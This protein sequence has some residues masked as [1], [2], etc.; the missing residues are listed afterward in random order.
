MFENKK[1]IIK[2]IFII[3]VLILLIGNIVLF[4]YLLNVRYQFIANVEIDST[5]S[6]PIKTIV[7]I[8]TTVNVPVIIPIMGQQVTVAVPIDTNVPI[9][10]TIQVPIKTTVPVEIKIGDLIF[11][12]IKK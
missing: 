6:V 4:I 5:F 9:D 11:G 3:L 7:P 12:N 2:Y 10:T 1:T 8:K